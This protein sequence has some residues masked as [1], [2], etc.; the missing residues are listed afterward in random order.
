MHSIY[1]AFVEKT[2]H[3][4]A[5]KSTNRANLSK[6]VEVT[7]VNVIYNPAAAN[8]LNR[9]I[10]DTDIRNGLYADSGYTDLRQSPK[11]QVYNVPP[12]GLTNTTAQDKPSFQLQT[13]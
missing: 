3:E 5:S 8:T 2:Q 11:S 4:F 12:N 7:K 9:N 10:V 6:D 13:P 1:L